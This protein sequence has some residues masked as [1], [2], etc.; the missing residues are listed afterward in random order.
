MF[1]DLLCFF[2]VSA[3]IHGDCIGADENAHNICLNYDSITINIRPCNL[4]NQRAF[5]EGGNIIAPPEAP[6]SR[7]KKIVDDGS[8]L[9]ACPFTDYE[10]LRSG[11]WSTIRYAKK[12][13]K[14]Y[15]IIWPNGQTEHSDRSE[16]QE[17]L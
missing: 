2:E 3:L 4:N 13:G 17:Y 10:E 11:T 12:I 1:D 7:N 9:I 6:L 15:T 14:P 8:R 16:D 5:C